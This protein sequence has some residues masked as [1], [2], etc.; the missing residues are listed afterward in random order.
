MEKFQ[1]NFVLEISLFISVKV[2]DVI[3]AACRTI[4]TSIHNILADNMLVSV[5][6]L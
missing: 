2:N 4:V 1:Y 3:H 6:K 5:I